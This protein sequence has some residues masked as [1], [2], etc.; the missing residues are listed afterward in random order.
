M[1]RLIRWFRTWDER[2]YAEFWAAPDPTTIRIYRL[3][4]DWQARGE[5]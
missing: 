1:K 4:Y 2:R 3:P 5:L